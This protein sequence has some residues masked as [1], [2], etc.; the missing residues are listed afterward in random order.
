VTVVG[1]ALIAAYVALVL[2][3]ERRRLQTLAAAN[4]PDEESNQRLARRRVRFATLNLACGL[5]TLFFTAV[6]TA[7]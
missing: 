6:A 4:R 7:Q 1:M 2:E 3:P 5:L